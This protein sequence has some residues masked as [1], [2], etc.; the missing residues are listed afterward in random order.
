MRTMIKHNLKWYKQAISLLLCVCIM[1]SGMAIV[2]A[3]A[4]AEVRVGYLINNANQA[5]YAEK[6]M[7]KKI[8]TMYGSDEGTIS[9][10]TNK[11]VRVK[12][13]VKGGTKSGYIPRSAV[14]VDTST[15]QKKAMANMTAYKRPSTKE[16]FGEI[17]KNDKVFVVG[18][19]SRN[20]FVQVRYPIG[21][22]K[23]KYAWITTANAQKYLSSASTSS[24]QGGTSTAKK[25]M[26]SPISQRSYTGIPYGKGPNGRT[27]YVSDSGC[28]LLTMINCVNVLVG[29]RPDVKTMANWSVKNGYRVNGQG[30]KD[31]FFKAWLSAYGA[32]YGVKYIGAKSSF[33]DVKKALTAGNVI[34][35]HVDSHF[36]AI[37]KYDSNT[38]KYLVFDSYPSSARGTSSGSRWLK[39]SDFKGRMSLSTVTSTPFYVIGKR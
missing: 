26:P 34:A 1:A 35:C 11:T 19:K 10:V 8:G 14:L 33:S 12:Y 39:Q 37:V 23:Y 30:T 36:L 18:S 24:S 32:N 27:A 22:N 6:A 3:Q 38:G 21:S 20:G 28:A 25:A 2:K 9:E 13:P 16:K 7:T 29:K 15:T 5:V 31:A 17:Y 4:A